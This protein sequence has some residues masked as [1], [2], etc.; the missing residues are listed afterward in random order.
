M[1][2]PVC[3]VDLD[4]TLFQIP[5]KMKSGPKQKFL[6]PAAVD[7][8]EN[9]RSFMTPE[10]HHFFYW[11]QKNTCLIPVTARSRSELSRVRLG[12]NSWK[13][14]AH[15][16]LIIRPDGKIDE[17]WKKQ[18]IGQ[19]EQQADPL[20][21]LHQRVVNRLSRFHDLSITLYREYNLPL[22]LAVK[23]HN[24]T[25]K[26]KIR[27]IVDL[28]NAEFSGTAFKM[29]HNNNTIHWLPHYLNKG[30]AAGY[31]LNRLRNQNDSLVVLGFGDSASD[32]SFL[33]QCSWFGLPSGS[34]L[35][36]LLQDCLEYS[37]AAS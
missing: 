36:R 5:E 30:R 16:G 17:S 29:H 37:E 33:K 34:Q 28:L 27:E 31:L 15:G 22:Y 12:F 26:Q 10:Q 4:D 13:I 25:V 6:T 2:K 23:I 20:T 24:I 18:L 14:A 9:P 35:D 8:Q 11:L 19:T 7:E 3:L 21:V 32:Y 1:H